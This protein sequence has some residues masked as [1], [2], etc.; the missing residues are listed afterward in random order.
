VA[1]ISIDLA[2]R[3]Y[4]DIG[5]AI[6]E[7][8]VTCVRVK[9]VQPHERD[10]DGTPDFD[11]LVQLCTALATES[12]A[13]LILINVPK[14]WRASSSPVEHMRFCERCTFTET[15]IV[16]ILRGTPLT[17]LP[18][19]SNPIGVQQSVVRRPTSFVVTSALRL[20]QRTSMRARRHPVD[21]RRRTWRRSLE[22]DTD[23]EA[24][25]DRGAGGSDVA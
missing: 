6:L 7:G 21:E 13:S 22:S 15:Q 2:S 20:S 23:P 24:G 17:C 16:S 8:S 19:V 11:R 14:A 9:L 10:L 12:G 25:T 5:I 3:R 4:R 1:V 18:R